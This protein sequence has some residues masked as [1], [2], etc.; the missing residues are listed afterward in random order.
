MTNMKK[1]II[2]L[3][4]KTVEELTKEIRLQREEIAKFQLEA[5]TNPVKDTN[6]LVKKRK[7]LA[8]LLT[9]LTEK[10]TNSN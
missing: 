8:V 1:N 10:K 5:K 6:S 9:V 7:K 2:D 3:R 4:K